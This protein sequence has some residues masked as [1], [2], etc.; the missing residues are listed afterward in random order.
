MIVLVLP[1]LQSLWRAKCARRELRR[2]RAEAREAGKLMQDKQALESKL[3][4]VQNVLATVQN[5]RNELR[6][7]FRVR[8]AA[9]ALLVLLRRSC[10]WPA[11]HLTCL[12]SKYRCCNKLSLCFP[13]PS[14]QKLAVTPAESA[15]NQSVLCNTQCLP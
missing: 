11:S 4:D 10:G 14:L 15:F 8:T 1:P 9:S 12:L 13:L 2:R 3:K 7:Q 5:Q 6:Q